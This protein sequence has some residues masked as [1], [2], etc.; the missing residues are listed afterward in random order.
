MHGAPLLREGLLRQRHPMQCQCRRGQLIAMHGPYHQHAPGRHL[1]GRR[2]HIAPGNGA[3]THRLRT[4]GR[5]LRLLAQRAAQRGPARQPGGT[6]RRR[7]AG[8]G[9]QRQDGHRRR[10]RCN[11]GCRGGAL[12]GRLSPSR[13]PMLHVQMVQGHRRP[14]LAH[15]LHRIPAHATQPQAEQYRQ[16]QAAPTRHWGSGCS[17]TISGAIR[18]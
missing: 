5:Q 1:A 4:A 17:S 10:R 14:C 8:I 15:L 7:H 6:Y 12:R 3:T 11:T 2:C 18:S 16:G 13:H 9:R